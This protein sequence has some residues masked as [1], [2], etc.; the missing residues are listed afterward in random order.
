MSKE[1]E[2][3]EAQLG[4]CLCEICLVKDG[5]I[6]YLLSLLQI[7]RSETSQRERLATRFAGRKTSQTSADSDLMAEN[8]EGLEIERLYRA[9]K[10]DEWG[11]DV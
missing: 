4:K 9:I 1:I 5:Q 7:A 11:K 6:K 8:N 3:I 10:E 2:K